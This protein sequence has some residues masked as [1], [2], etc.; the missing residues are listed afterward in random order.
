MSCQ[1]SSQRCTVCVQE[2]HSVIPTP[3]P[4]L[5]RVE[6]LL[7]LWCLFAWYYLSR[8]LLSPFMNSPACLPLNMSCAPPPPSP[9][10][11]IPQ[12][13]LFAC[14]GTEDT[15]YPSVA[16]ASRQAYVLVSLKAMGLE[17]LEIG[18][19]IIAPEHM[20]CI[21]VHV[22]RAGRIASVLTKPA[23]RHRSWS[24]WMSQIARGKP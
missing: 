6:L 9:K 1:V 17:V 18:N 11:R 15:K 7:V 21:R 13:N 19:P 14:F 23:S 22:V 24:R 10:R 5:I 16:G 12:R 2:A 8:H 20:V 3:I 4:R